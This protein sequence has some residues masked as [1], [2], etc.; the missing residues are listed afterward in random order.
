MKKTCLFLTLVISAGH[1]FAQQL[2]PNLGDKVCALWTAVAERTKTDT[3]VGE[4]LLMMDWWSMGYLKGMATQYAFAQKVSSP[5][6]KIRGDEEV[7][8]MRAYCE[9]NPRKNISDAALA[10]LEELES[11]PRR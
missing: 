11:R 1:P 6:L 9:A 3:S 2:V 10:F 7:D 8:W 4:Q 5:L